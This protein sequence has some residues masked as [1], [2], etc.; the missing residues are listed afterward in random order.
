MTVL[1][2]GTIKHGFC[3]REFDVFSIHLHFGGVHSHGG[4]LKQM[5]YKGKSHL[6]KWMMTGGTPISGFPPFCCELMFPYFPMCSSFKCPR[7]PEIRQLSFGF[8]IVQLPFRSDALEDEKV[9]L[10]KTEKS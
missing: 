7:F 6:Y 9:M 8:H 2:S 5:V 3:P 10:K 4:T 1:P